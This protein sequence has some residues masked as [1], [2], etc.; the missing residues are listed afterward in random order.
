MDHICKLKQ[1]GYKLNWWRKHEVNL[2]NTAEIQLIPSRKQSVS[3]PKTDYLILFLEMVVVYSEDH[4][5]HT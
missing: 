1:N 5:I 4:T 2:N 3:I